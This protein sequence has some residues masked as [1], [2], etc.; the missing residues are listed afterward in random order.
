MKLRNVVVMH[1]HLMWKSDHWRTTWKSE[2]HCD[3]WSISVICL[4]CIKTHRS[5]VH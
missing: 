4:S 2:E 1:F 3:H 5:S